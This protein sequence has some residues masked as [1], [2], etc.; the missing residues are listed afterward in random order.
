M[1]LDASCNEHTLEDLAE[2]TSQFALADHGMFMM[3]K[4]CLFDFLW[5]DKLI[6]NP[7]D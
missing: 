2:E 7:L 4:F 6:N 1:L 5:L 3:I